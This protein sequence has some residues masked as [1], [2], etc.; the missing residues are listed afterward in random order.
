MLGGFHPFG[1]HLEVEI[2]RQVDHGVDQLAVLLTLF[3]AT[4]KTAIDLEQGNRQT[5]EVDEG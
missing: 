2:M 5:I 3:H 1:H 4:N